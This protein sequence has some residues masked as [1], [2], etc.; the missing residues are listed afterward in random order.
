MSFFKTATKPCDKTAMD[1]VKKGIEA[2][3][4]RMKRVREALQSVVTDEEEV[5]EREQDSIGRLAL[6]AARN[7]RR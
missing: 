4:S 2:K 7:G 3:K 6:V 1:E 5:P